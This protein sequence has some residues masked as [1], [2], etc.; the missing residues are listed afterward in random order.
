M[1]ALLLAR[2]TQQRSLSAVRCNALNGRDAVRL[3]SVFPSSAGEEIS[4]LLRNSMARCRGHS[5]PKL[6]PPW[7]RWIQFTCKNAV[8]FLIFTS[9]KHR[10]ESCYTRS[11]EN[12]NLIFNDASHRRFQ[13]PDTPGRLSSSGNTDTK[14]W[15][16]CRYEAPEGNGVFGWLNRVSLCWKQRW[17]KD[18]GTLFARRVREQENLEVDG[19]ITRQCIARVQ[20]F[21]DSIPENI[22]NVPL[23]RHR[24]MSWPLGTSCTWLLLNIHLNMIFSFPYGASQDICQPA[25]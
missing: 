25:T 7:V 17:H 13:P 2:S 6:I 14:H 24:R 8:S 10:N 20:L 23:S 15:V 3:N 1:W 5:N 16:P 22:F 4:H 21:P 19:R 9:S 11:R 18:N 12:L